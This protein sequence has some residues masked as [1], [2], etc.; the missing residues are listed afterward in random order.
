MCNWPFSLVLVDLAKDLLKRLGWKGTIVFLREEA[1][2]L[3]DL[4][5]NFD[6][7]SEF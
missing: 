6:V 4:L 2:G 3:Q 5:G 1:G 7:A